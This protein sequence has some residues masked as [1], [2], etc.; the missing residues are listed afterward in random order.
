MR[1]EFLYARY[2]SQGSTT[3]NQLI[4]ANSLTLAMW[5]SQIN[6]D[7]GYDEWGQWKK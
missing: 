6:K 1:D 7:G 4:A 2:R 5:K 3:L